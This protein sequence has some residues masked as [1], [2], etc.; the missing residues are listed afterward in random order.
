MKYFKLPDLGE[1]LI[2]AEIVEWHIKEGDT[3]S[4]DQLMVSVETAKAIV[5]IPSPQ[6]G[7][8]LAL[9]GQ[10]GDVIHTGEPL[11]EYEGESD[12][13]GTVVGDLSVANK[14]ADNQDAKVD[15]FIIGS[16]YGGTNQ[17]TAK[18]IKATPAYAH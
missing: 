18:T 1:G 6:S 2:E 12:D 15:H 16:A 17:T 8:V 4:V 3:V 13:T 11:V 9:F 7:C 5:D 10:E 14:G